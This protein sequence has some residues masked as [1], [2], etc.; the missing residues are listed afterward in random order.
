MPWA[1]VAGP[2]DVIDALFTATSAVCVTG[3]IVVD[4]GGAFTSFGHAVLGEACRILEFPAPASMAGMPISEIQGEE[5][6]Y[7]IALK[8]SGSGVVRVMPGPEYQVGENDI[9]LVLGTPE[10]FEK[11]K[12]LKEVAEGEG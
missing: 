8:E 10:G 9:L 7:V 3:L 12:A 5:D 2:L 4:T 1:S 11:S 6:V